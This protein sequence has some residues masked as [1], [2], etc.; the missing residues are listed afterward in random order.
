VLSLPALAGLR[1]HS[2]TRRAVRT[3]VGG[4]PAIL[5]CLYDL[6]K[7]RAEMLVE[8]FRTHPRSCWTAR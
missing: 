7:V 4:M 2:R 1:M 5:M 6:Q 3:L 8:R